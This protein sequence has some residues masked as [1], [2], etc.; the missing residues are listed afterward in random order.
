MSVLRIWFTANTTGSFT[1]YLR[2]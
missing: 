2:L 1:H